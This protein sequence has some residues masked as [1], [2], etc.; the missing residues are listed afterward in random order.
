MEQTDCPLCGSNG[1][2]ILYR[3]ENRTS[4]TSPSF[5]LVRCS[6][7]SLGYLNPRPTPDGM[8]NYYSATC[9]P[10]TGHP[11]GSSPIGQWLFRYGLRKRC[12]PLLKHQP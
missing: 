10:C 8:A 5:T 11:G 3:L 6:Q 1:S 4:Q 12:R 9:C 2:T 7:C